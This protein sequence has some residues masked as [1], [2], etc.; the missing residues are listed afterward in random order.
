MLT[1]AEYL[2]DKELPA[3]R[4]FWLA[5]QD[6]IA[7]CLRKDKGQS[8]F[9]SVCDSTHRHFDEWTEAMQDRAQDDD[10]FAEIYENAYQPKRRYH[11]KQ[12][13]QGLFDVD[14]Y[15][16]QEDQLFIE[17]FKEFDQGQSISVLMDLAIPWSERNDP[18]MVQRHQKVYDLI[19][20]CDSE[21]QPLQI[22]ACLEI[23]IPEA[24][25][26]LKIFII[27]KDYTDNIFPSIWGILKSNLTGNAFVNV[28]MDYFI[29]TKA[30][31]NGKLRPMKNVEQYLPEQEQVLYFGSRI[32]S[33]T[34]TKLGS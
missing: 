9:G 7:H 10:N 13:D 33:K 17:R 19:A 21:D 34:G 12:S 24:S 15:I 14:A 23:K 16:E 30:S 3:N 18:C 20:Q 6:I 31:G 26:N 28:I 2:Q 5:G 29:G 11:C 32:E 27:V 22:I 4:Q 1:P 8:F 25:K